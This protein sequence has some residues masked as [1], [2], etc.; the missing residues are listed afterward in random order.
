MYNNLEILNKFDF[1]LNDQ[2]IEKEVQIILRDKMQEN[3]NADILSFLYSCIDLTSLNTDDSKESIWQLTS[4]V[5]DFEHTYPGLSNVAAICVFPNFVSTVKE[6]LTTNVNIAAVA[7]GFPSSQTFME[8]KIAEVSLAL[9][10]GAQEID[11]VCNLGYLLDDEIE[12]LYTE[13]SEIKEICRNATLKVIVESGLLQSAS[14]IK[15]A[16]IISML[17]GADFIK[18]STGKVY[19]GATPEA[20]YVM[21]QAIKE[22]HT[23]CGVQTGI[24]VSGGI[25]TTTDAIK[26]YTLVKELLGDI[27]LTPEYF[28]IGASSLADCILQEID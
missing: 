11:I 9:L 12:E 1:I 4:K 26:Y 20:V 22:Y 14:L 8:V 19:P 18:T 15:K 5:N 24:K 7:G 16:S 2:Q 27:W 21:C 6:S 28:R 10:D 23:L 3:N 17:S 13:I 25:K